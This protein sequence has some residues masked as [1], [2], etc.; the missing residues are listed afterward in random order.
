METALELVASRVVVGRATDRLPDVA[1]DIARTGTHHLVVLHEKTGRL[2]GIVKLAD[3]A[4]RA[5]PGTRILAD[6]VPPIRPLTVQPGESAAAVSEL[7]QRH[8][9][10]EV[11]VVAA[12]GSYLGLITSESV[13][14]WNLAELQRTRN[15]LRLEEES[16]Q[17]ARARLEAVA[18]EKDRFLTNLSHTLRAPLNPVLLIATARANSEQLPEELRRDFDTI[19][20]NAALEAKFIN[21]LIDAARSAPPSPPPVR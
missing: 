5:N 14:E 15:L 3:I 6:L 11:P 8:R 7:F 12:D 4:W 17:L 2:L 19:A 10:G 20:T 13:L 9:L 18:S 21:D 16:A 1:A